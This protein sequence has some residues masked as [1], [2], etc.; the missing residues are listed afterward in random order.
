MVFRGIAALTA[1]GD[2]F[3]G[4][5]AYTGCR[6][7][8]ALALTA[9]RID[10]AELHQHRQIV[11]G[12]AADLEDARVLGQIGIARDVIVQDVA[13]RGVPPMRR[14]MLRHAVVDDTVHLIRTPTGG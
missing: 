6:I 11:P 2:T 5:L 14:I 7:S 4:V 12:A 3:C 9:D 8:E 10:L 13:A 1:A